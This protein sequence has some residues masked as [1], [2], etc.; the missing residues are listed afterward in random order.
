[1]MSRN[2]TRAG[3]AAAMRQRHALLSQEEENALARA[4]QQNGDIAAR[5]ALVTA[6]LAYAVSKTFGRTRPGQQDDAEQEAVL[7]LMAAADRY[8]PDLG[9]RFATYA[10]WWINANLSLHALRNQSM[11]HVGHASYRR[12]L[13]SLRKAIAKVTADLAAET[14]QTPRSDILHAEVARMLG[15]KVSHVEKF[16]GLILSGDQSLNAPVRNPDGEASIE[17]I[18]LLED[19]ETRS[20]LLVETQQIHALMDQSVKDAL[21][22]LTLR[23]RQIIERRHLDPEYKATLQDLANDMGV[24]RERI[25]QIESAALRKMGD[26]LRKAGRTPALFGF[27]PKEKPS[28]SRRR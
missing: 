16:S 24:T 5:N 7:G 20:D 19:R 11:V 14:G 27:S 1:M 4:W 15:V 6:H 26:R 12:M 10:S 13:F 8:D 17:L 28:A 22:F 2:G 21:D 25:R 9:W 18:D 23:E 3:T